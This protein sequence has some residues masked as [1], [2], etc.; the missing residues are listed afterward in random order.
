MGISPWF[1]S[2]RATRE[3]VPR[4]LVP[5]TNPDRAGEQ[6]HQLEIGAMEIGARHHFFMEI[7]A[8]HQS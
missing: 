1:D 7:G 8:R 3:L 6:G 4:E 2:G 5:G